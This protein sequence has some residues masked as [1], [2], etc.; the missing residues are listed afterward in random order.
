MW[1]AFVHVGCIHQKRYKRSPST[2]YPKGIRLVCVSKKA[3]EKNDWGFRPPD[4]P[5]MEE[6]YA[7]ELAYVEEKFGP[8]RY[9][10]PEKADALKKRI[11]VNQEW[12]KQE[13]SQG[14]KQYQDIKVTI[15][16][17]TLGI[18]AFLIPCIWWLGS[19]KTA[20]SYAL[21]LGGSLGYV[22]LLSTSVERL[23]QSRA[24]PSSWLAPARLAIVA[25]CI[26]TAARHREELQVLP[27]FL[28]FLTYKIAA[29]VPL[30]MDSKKDST[31]SSSTRLVL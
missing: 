28:G 24:T 8:K 12:A 6:R 10:T 22:W 27:V 18:G 16:G 15:L 4:I 2:L 9:E 26:I 1:L 21:G 7:A 17:A 31:E 13:R 23:G 14:L 25:L 30:W 3:K 20:L 19:G 29:F 5:T 11:L